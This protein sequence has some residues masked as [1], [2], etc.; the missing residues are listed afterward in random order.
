[1][2]RFSCNNLA[3]L[4]AIPLF[5]EKDRQDLFLHVAKYILIMESASLRATILIQMILR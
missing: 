4:Y 3:E 5:A 1:M 2:N